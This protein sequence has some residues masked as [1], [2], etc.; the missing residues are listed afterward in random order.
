MLANEG[1]N[2]LGQITVSVDIASTFDMSG[3]TAIG[4]NAT[5]TDEAGSVFTQDAGTIYGNVLADTYAI[6]ACLMGT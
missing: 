5:V 3:N 4:E 2:L 6:D 1:G